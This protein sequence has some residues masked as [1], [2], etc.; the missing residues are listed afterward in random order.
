MNELRWSLVSGAF[1][2]TRTMYHTAACDVPSTTKSGLFD[3][4]PELGHGVENFLGEAQPG[5]MALPGQRVELRVRQPADDVL[6]VS[7]RDDVVAV[8][9]PPADRDLHLV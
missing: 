4:V 5:K 1:P 9:M 2:G 3:A 6:P 7:E 8:A